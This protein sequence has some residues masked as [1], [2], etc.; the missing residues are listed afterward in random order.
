MPRST[1]YVYSRSFHGNR[2]LSIGAICLATAAGICVHGS[3]AASSEARLVPGRELHRSHGAFHQREHGAWRW[4]PTASESR[5][6]TALGEDYQLRGFLR[7]AGEPAIVW[8]PQLEGTDEAS[9]LVLRL[10]SARGL[11]ALALLPPRA[12]RPTGAETQGWTEFGRERVRVGRAAVR[13]MEREAKPQCLAVMGISAGGHAAVA[14]AQLEP[15]ADVLVAMLAGS[16]DGARAA[17]QGLF[18]GGSFRP[19]AEVSSL[20]R[21]PHLPPERTLVVRALLDEVIRPD[22]TDSLAR[23]LGHPTE[24]V[25]PSGHESFRAFLPLA[26]WRALGFVERACKVAPA[27]GH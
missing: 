19:S 13:L 27:P 6:V 15:S 8:L 16:E 14:V 17:G 20:L 22:A 11:A 2:A 18:P 10:A 3:L 12:A 23:A 5:V 4:L 21:R 24:H 1:R 7:A 25:Y 9:E 26:I